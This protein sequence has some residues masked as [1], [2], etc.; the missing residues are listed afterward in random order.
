MEDGPEAGAAQLAPGLP[1]V[2]G[3]RPRQAGVAFGAHSALA[4]LLSARDPAGAAAVLPGAAAYWERTW[5]WVSTGEDVEYRWSVWAPVHALML[6]GVPASAYPSFGVVPFAYGFEQV[7][8]MNYY[9]GRLAA[10][11]ESPAVAVL[12][13]WH[14]WSVLRGL[15][16]TVLVFE[17]ASWSL[18]RLTGRPLSTRR[19]RIARWSAGVGLAVADAVVKLALSP[20]IREQLFA[21]LGP[22]AG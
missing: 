4:I 22:G 21:N 16:Y 2:R 11:S 13:G 20:F 17:A 7:D 6:A 15:A 19:R 3:R 1:G 10:V 5:L 12:F 14:P 9:V 8:L 18:E